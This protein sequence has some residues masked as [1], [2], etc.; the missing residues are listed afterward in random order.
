MA[1]QLK[2][3]K[4]FSTGMGLPRPEIPDD[5]NLPADDPMRGWLR[6]MRQFI[7]VINGV[8]QIKAPGPKTIKGDLFFPAWTTVSSFSGGWGNW[9]TAFPDAAYCIDA[10]NIVRVIGALKN[11]TLGSAAFTMGAA[12]APSG[13][14]SGRVLP[15]GTESQSGGSFIGGRVDINT[16][17][18][19]VPVDGNNSLVVI[20]LS[21]RAVGP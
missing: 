16:N 19:L 9:G 21:Y 11:G 14:P 7:D 2:S 1:Q 10:F 13:V 6:R 12:Y 3:N 8:V 5:D 17:G 4:D 18:Q 20:T 15:I